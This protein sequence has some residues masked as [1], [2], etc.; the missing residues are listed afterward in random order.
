MPFVLSFGKRD[1]HGGKNSLKKCIEAHMGG[2]CLLAHTV[3]H[4]IKPVER[5]NLQLALDRLMDSDG[6]GR[7]LTGYSAVDHDHDTSLAHA[8]ARDN[9]VVAPVEREQLSRGLG[10]EL[11]C[12]S[13]G[14]YLLRHQSEPIAIMI[15]VRDYGFRQHSLEVMAHK[16]EIAHAALSQLLADANRQSVYK[17]KTIS[18][19]MEQHWQHEIVVRFHEMP[20]A[21]RESIIL[22][23]AVM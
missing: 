2:E 12:V 11:D 20:E 22:P 15:R 14:L 8:L 3:S 1:K 23:A 16:R 4:V 13:R 6:A 9:L 18:L 7:T 19:E 21:A 5:V 17:G 10:K